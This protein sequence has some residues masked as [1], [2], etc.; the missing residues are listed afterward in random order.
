MMQTRFESLGVYLP[1]QM[2]STQELVARMKNRPV[3]DLEKLTGIQYRR[4]RDENEDS[5]S[6][7]LAA[8]RK[9]LESSRY[10]AGDLDVIICSSITRFKNGLSFY[11]EPALSKGLKSDLGLRP[12][13]LNFDITNACAGMLTGLF[14]LDNMI[15]SGQVRTGMVVSGE[16]ITPITETAVK[17]IRE[18][19]DRQFASLTVGDSGA[20]YILDRAT[21]DTEGIEMVEFMTM[22]EFAELCFGMPSS[23]NSGVAMYTDAM[24]IHKE[25][26]QRLPYLM[27]YIMKKHGISP[28]DIDFI[29]PHQTSSRAIHSALD[30]CKQHFEV[31]PEICI[32]LDKFGNTS[33]TSHFVVLND[34][35]KQGKIKKGSRVLFIALASGIVVGFVLAR[36]G[37]IQIRE[38]QIQ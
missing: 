28:R 24:A 6:I 14:I 3:F 11:M 5:Y 13:A 22:S 27:G 38:T 32:S 15:R 25:V 29:I 21:E 10:S 9:C 1:S 37:G 30:L 16:C 12:G 8:A 19:V 35:I 31:S 33:T 23:E 36:I 7:A 20:A 18:P 34:Y 26:I 2:V 4:W 17:E